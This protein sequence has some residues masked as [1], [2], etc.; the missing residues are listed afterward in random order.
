MP[1]FIRGVCVYLSNTS[2]DILIYFGTLS[3][4]YMNKGGVD[5]FPLTNLNQM[6]LGID[7]ERPIVELF[8]F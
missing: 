8:V 2:I 3:L 1:T 6:M 7:G 5:K 4:E